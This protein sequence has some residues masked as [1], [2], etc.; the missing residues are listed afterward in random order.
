MN[1]AW[2]RTVLVRLDIW[3]VEFM[4]NKDNFQK[5]EDRDKD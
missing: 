4:D 2:E 1:K 5:P 3:T